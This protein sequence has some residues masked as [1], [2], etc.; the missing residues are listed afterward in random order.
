MLVLTR[1]AE[2]SI[3]IGDSIVITVL[4]IEGDRVKL[5]ITAPREMT[6]LRQE[7]FEAVQAQAHLQARLAEEPEPK[8]F[9]ELRNLLAEETRQTEEPSAEPPPANDKTKK[10]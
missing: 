4:A 7:I 6:I 9:E 5:G 3:S 2:E 8:S 1:R 10:D